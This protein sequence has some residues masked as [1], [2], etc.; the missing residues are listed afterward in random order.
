ML[1]TTHYTAIDQA[2]LR[3]TLRIRSADGGTQCH[4]EEEKKIK[5]LSNKFD[6]QSP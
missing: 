5:I 3:N 4:D 2:K 1:R 6:Q